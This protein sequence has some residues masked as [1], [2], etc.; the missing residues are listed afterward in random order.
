MAGNSR[1]QV[2]TQKIQYVQPIQPPTLG[3][4]AREHL[5]AFQREYTIYIQKTK[6]NDLRPQS[7]KECMTGPILDLAAAH[8][9]KIPL[10]QI[11]NEDIDQMVNDL[12]AKEVTLSATQLSTMFNKCV[13]QLSTADPE[14]RVMDFCMA[15][16]QIAA[17]HG[18]QEQITKNEQL[19]KQVVLSLIEGVRPKT[20]KAVVRCTERSNKFF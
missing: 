1:N 13:M 7:M 12:L 9:L 5:V 19:A 3:D 16:R 14:K 20:L 11:T 15:Y 4:L 8:I 10:Q 2:A 17:V 18:L 6:A